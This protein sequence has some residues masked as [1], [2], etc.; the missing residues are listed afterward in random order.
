MF[1]VACQVSRTPA[2]VSPIISTSTW[3]IGF[4]PVESDWRYGEILQA[5]CIQ[6]LHFTLTAQLLPDVAGSGSGTARFPPTVDPY[7]S[8]IFL[9]SLSIIWPERRDASELFRGVWSGP[10]TAEI[11]GQDAARYS[12]IL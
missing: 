9:V 12:L 3:E 6:S 4:F 2:P 5:D 10:V 1:T 7:C 8:S 11:L